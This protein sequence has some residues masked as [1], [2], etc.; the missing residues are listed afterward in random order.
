MLGGGADRHRA[1]HPAASHTHVVYNRG[2]A[3]LSGT[4]DTY[5]YELGNIWPGS[6]WSIGAA[7]GRVGARLHRH[8]LLAE[9]PPWYRRMRPVLFALAV[10]LPVSALAGF[11][12]AGRQVAAPARGA[13]CLG[14]AAGRLAC[15]G[16]S[17][18]GT[19]RPRCTTGCAS[20]FLAL[21][22][23]ALLVPLVRSVRR[24]AGAKVEITYRGGPVVRVPQGP[25]L[26]EIS[27]MKR[28]AARLGVRRPRALLDLPG[29]RG[30][31]ARRPACRR[32]APKP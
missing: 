2:A 12:V 16:C 27:R 9:P 18:R 21:L 22:A 32:A 3:T 15:A 28:R 30:E 6:R 26:L 4:D 24:A 20:T 1:F 8:A 10:A 19:P 7:A 29:G 5:A 31:R 23:L 17:G 14:E 11:S 13:G 25:T